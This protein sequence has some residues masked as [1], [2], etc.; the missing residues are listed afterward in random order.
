VNTVAAKGAEPEEQPI[1]PAPIGQTL[2]SAPR[3]ESLIVPAAARLAVAAGA[4]AGYLLAL[5]RPYWVPLTL[6]LGLQGQNLLIMV[7][8]AIQLSLGT[9]GSVVLG[10]ALLATHPNPVVLAVLLA[11][12]GLRQPARRGA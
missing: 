2:T 10:G 1:A 11:V 5:D 12:L 8:Q 6:A 9:T 3:R 4:T 7:E